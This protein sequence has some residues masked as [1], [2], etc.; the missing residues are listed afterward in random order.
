[1]K[2]PL[3]KKGPL[4]ATTTPYRDVGIGPEDLAATRLKF[5]PELKIVV[6]N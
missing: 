4:L 2:G 1:M 5:H 3:F 6:I